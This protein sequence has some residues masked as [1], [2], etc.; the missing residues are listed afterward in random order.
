MQKK[1]KIK[2]PVLEHNKIFLCSKH[3]SSRKSVLPL[4]SSFCCVKWNP[5]FL[6]SK[7]LT[8]AR[9]SVI[10]MGVESQGVIHPYFQADTT[11]FKWM[12]FGFITLTAFPCALW[13]IAPVL[14][15]LV[16]GWKWAGVKWASVT[17]GI[18]IQLLLLN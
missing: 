6:T 4:G 10:G 5:G 7:M 13:C 1:K 2:I 3:K 16:T 8:V 14:S 9:W 11:C 12:V 18:S 17:I 15:N